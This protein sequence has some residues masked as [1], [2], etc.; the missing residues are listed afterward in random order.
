MQPLRSITITVTSSLLRAAPPLCLASVLSFLWGLHLNF[1]LNIGTTASHVPHKSL[2]H[3]H[4]AFMP[5]AAQTIN[6]LPLDLSWGCL[7]TPVLA[8][9][10]IFRHLIN[11][12]RSLISLILT[13]HDLCRDFSL[14]LTT[15]AL[16]QRSLRQFETSSCKPVPRGLPSSFAQLHTLYFYI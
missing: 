10:L 3:V 2:I 11:G 12:S 5:D 7:S 6:R 1:S 13:C 9:S 4:A 15:P 8:P 14:T 16:Y